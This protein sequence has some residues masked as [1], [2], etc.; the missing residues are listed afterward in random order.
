F[1][2]LSVN[3]FLFFMLFIAFSKFGSIR[4]GGAN[5]KP[6]FSK[7]AWF[8]M[9]F[10]AG[11]GIGI[12]FWSV[13][14]PVSHFISPPSAEGETVE[15]A[16]QAM[17][18]TFLHWGLH[19]W[20][21][22]ALVGMA[23]AFFTF[24]KKLPLT[25]SSIFQ[26]LIGNRIHGP[27]GKS[28]NVLAV[29]ATLFGLAT[30]LGL[31]VQQVSAGLA[32]LIDI[33]DTITVQVILITVITLGATASV[34][35]G[36]SAGVKRLSEINIVL[37]AIFLAFIV[38]V[39]P[40]LF[41]LDSYTQNVGYYI[42]SFFEISF[43]TETYQQS[44][45]QNSWTVFYWAWWISWSPFVGMFIAR[46]SRGRTLREFVLGVLIVP[47][48]ITFL[49]LSA[50]GGSAIFL[51]LNSLADIATAVQENVATSLYI[52]LEEYPL[53]SITSLVGVLLVTSFFVTSSDSGSLVVDS[54]TAGGKLDA[55][56]PQRVFWAL[57]EG[58]I[59]AVLLIGGGLS[60][61]QT[62]AII[63][64]LP[65][66]IILIILMFSLLRGLREEHDALMSAHRK[67]EREDYQRTITE[68]IRKREATRL[69][70]SGS[71]DST[72]EN[73]DNNS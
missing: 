4:L 68:L 23:L 70:K 71:S 22:Y 31:G 64:G 2:I 61:L 58:A 50:F 57:T 21:I 20:G 12:L 41:I 37:G 9:L 40:T 45:W 72:S 8:A 63:T 42:Q 24:N 3:L 18:S 46:I 16:R 33:P 27:L 62:A 17:Q 14:E 29:V 49:W 43:W 55:P 10:S 25:I 67:K 13:G 11:M 15:A 65:F 60:A 47:T 35:A 44:D 54:L 5:A 7:G 51:E 53:A 28:I 52:L 48:L 36:L 34:I 66:A 69:N 56:V 19:A 30:S 26:P 32:H 1:F 73:K 6:E 39:G 38:A 59:A